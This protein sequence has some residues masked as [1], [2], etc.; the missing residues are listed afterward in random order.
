MVAR[1]NKMRN[2]P[3]QKMASAKVVVARRGAGL[4]PHHSGICSR[5]NIARLEECDLEFAIGFTRGRHP[6][7]TVNYTYH[8]ETSIPHERKRKSG[9]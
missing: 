2:G 5:A 6:Q 9:F 3:W 7:T 4:Q 8:A 1:D